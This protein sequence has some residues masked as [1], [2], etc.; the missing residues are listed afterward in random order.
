[1]DWIGKMET[2][3]H[4]GVGFRFISINLSE[5]CFSTHMYSSLLWDLEKFQLNDFSF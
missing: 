1:M 4:A 5:L 2:T 3:L